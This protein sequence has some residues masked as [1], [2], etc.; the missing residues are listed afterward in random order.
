MKRLTRNYKNGLWGCNGVNLKDI[1]TAA[2][3]ALYKLKLYEDTG[4]SPE[5]LSEVDREYEAL[6]REVVELRAYKQAAERKKEQEALVNGIE[7]AIDN[8]L[9]ASI[10][11]EDI[12]AYRRVTDGQNKMRDM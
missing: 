2:Y 7:W 3:G 6:S 11:P 9:A 4:L 5:Q 12:E 10:K 8:G 1:P